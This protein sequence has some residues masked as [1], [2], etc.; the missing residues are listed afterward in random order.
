MKKK[1]LVTFLALACAGASA[2]GLAACSS[3]SGSKDEGGGSGEGETHVHT[4]SNEW[5]SDAQ[6]HWHA[7]TCEHSSE[8]S[9]KAAH[10]WNNG[11]ITVQ[12]TCTTAGEKTYTCTVCGK[13]KTE[14]V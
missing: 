10:G 7:A 14:T 1:L 9:G 11:E 3:T 4:Y 12:P 5:T 6:Y 13:T 2:F 8:V